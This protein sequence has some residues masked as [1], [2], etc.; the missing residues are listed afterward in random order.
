MHYK[1]K[2]AA[3]VLLMLLLW[4]SN[5]YSQSPIKSSWGKG[6][7]VIA[8][9]SSFS[10]KFSTRFQTLYQGVTNPS[11]N[12]WDDNFTTRRFR[13]KFDGFAFSPTF[14]YKIEL[15]L[16]NR[17]IGHDTRLQSNNAD[18]IVLD[19]VAKWNF[20]PNLYLW[21]GQTKLPGNRERVISS[22]N[23][24]FVDRS[25][26]NA[27][28]T[29]DRDAGLQ[30]HHVHRV[31]QVV[32]RE[33]G[34][35]SM[36]EGRN[37]TVT[38]I[39]GYDY[40]ARVEV[41]PFGEFKG[42]GD[43]FNSDLLR[44]QTPKLSVAATYDYNDN[45]SREGGQLGDFLSEQRDLSTVFVDAMFKYRG[46]S[47]MG[48]YANKE[49][50]SSSTNQET[51]GPVVRRDAEGNI[52]E[53]FTTGNGLNLQAGYLF[54]TNWEIAGRYS[55][56]NPTPILGRRAQDQYTVGISKYI[57]GHSLKVQSD[58]T[59]LQQERREDAYMFRMQMEISL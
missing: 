30:L 19:A 34:A 22:Q 49:A 11:T 25:L 58:V 57:V 38:N 31:G 40:T 3:L 21:A 20:A 24:Q 2:G 14:V 17:D 54:K 42:N 43:Y 50:F 36:G 53:A 26:L 18:N 7:N 15:A 1:I 37:I 47:F 48:E 45:A 6:L 39:G 13:L 12:E 56:Y 16:S 5:A 28:F 4:S 41:L 59:L 27:R 10:L 9:D 23:L 35:I 33:I 46:F 55:N 44:E 32:L 52:E 29:L 8:V 51:P